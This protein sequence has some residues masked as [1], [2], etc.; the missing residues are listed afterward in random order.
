MK[1]RICNCL[2]NIGDLTEVESNHSCSFRMILPK[3]YQF[4]FKQY[5]R[6]FLHGSYELYRF[7]ILSSANSL[8]T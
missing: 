1:Y 4:S 8:S 5:S 7:M 2:I 6:C 3:V